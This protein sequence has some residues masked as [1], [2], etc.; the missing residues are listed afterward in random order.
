MVGYRIEVCI[1]LWVL[2]KNEK[3]KDG[4]YFSFFGFFLLFID[5]CFVL[6]DIEVGWEE[7]VVVIEI[8]VVF[9]V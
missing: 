2:E 6:R 9:L 8:V 5:L 3:V 1:V 4:F 7:V